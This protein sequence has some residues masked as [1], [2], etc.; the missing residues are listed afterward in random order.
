M[1]RSNFTQNKANTLKLHISL[2]IRI[3]A[4]GVIRTRGTRIRNPELY[5]PELLERAIFRCLNTP[6]PVRKASLIPL[7]P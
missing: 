3:G 1:R 4:P 5:P 7:S 6:F 2:K